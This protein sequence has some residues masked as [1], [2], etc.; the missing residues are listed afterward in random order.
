MR[1]IYVALVVPVAL[2]LVGLPLTIHKWNAAGPRSLAEVVQL[3]E[4]NG[5]YCTTMPVDDPDPK[6]LI[7]SAM[8]LDEEE[9][10]EVNL[11]IAR[12]G[13]ASCYVA[14][15]TASVHVDAGNARF[16]GGLFIHGDPAVINMLTGSKLP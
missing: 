15:D 4:K 1:Q 8:P 16:W 14:W 5:L 10:S 6:R 13:T 2:V 3:A 7:L 11:S 9:A 12:E